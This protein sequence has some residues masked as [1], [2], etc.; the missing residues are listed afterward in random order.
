MTELKHSG[1]LPPVAE[2]VF[3]PKGWAHVHGKDTRSGDRDQL[4]SRGE[5]G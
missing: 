3:A 1:D 2:A 4:V 5:G